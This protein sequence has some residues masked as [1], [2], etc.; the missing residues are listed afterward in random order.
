MRVNAILCAIAAL[1]FGAAAPVAGQSPPPT[2][3]EPPATPSSQPLEAEPGNAFC[4]VMSD[5]P[6][7]A[8]FFTLYKGRKVYLCCKRCRTRFEAD[9]E[10]YANNLL[11][12]A[13][14]AAFQESAPVQPEAGEEHQHT[15]SEEHEHAEGAEHQE[16]AAQTEPDEHTHDEPASPDTPDEHDD[17]HDHSAHAEDASGLTKAM[18][19]LGRFHVLA[20]HFP[21]ALLFVGALFELVSMLGAGER[22]RGVVRASVGLGA[23]SALLAAPLG[24]MNAIGAEYAG[25]LADVFWWHRLLG[26][27]TAGLAVVAWIAVEWRA[28]KPS[29][30]AIV[31]TRVAV[32]ASAALVGITGHLGGSLVFG[33][34]YLAP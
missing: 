22:A 34:E 27:T 25:V 30:N 9:P 32:F 19:Y 4:P 5:E 14:L 31:A 23:I 17:D 3:T 18:S 20:I 24:L 15:E 12:Q 10:A 6:I 7:D 29:A 28:R 11:P 1:S 26:L 2:S 21:I 13:T 8:S 16:Q 33:W